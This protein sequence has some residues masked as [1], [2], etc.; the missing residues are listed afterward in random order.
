MAGKPTNIVQFFLKQ[1]SKL[2]INK[3]YVNSN[4]NEIGLANVLVSRKHVTGT[5]TM[6]IFL[7]DLKCLGVKNVTFIF[8]DKEENV[9]KKVRK[10]ME[11]IEIDYNLAH[12]IIYAGLE[13]A[14]E[15]GISPHKDFNFSKFILQPDDDNIP[16]ID[17][18]TGDH[19]G[20]PHLIVENIIKY[21]KEIN[22]LKKTQG[23]GNFRVD[24]LLKP[25]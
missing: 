25:F 13:Y 11:I 8:N 4:F 22:I 17:V 23:E 6:A 14:L 5:I 2:P 19:E 3:C 12:N 10:N 18:H 9:L 24:L 21:S 7:V 16:L 1:V 20:K 15:L